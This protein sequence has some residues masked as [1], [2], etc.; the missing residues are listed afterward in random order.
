MYFCGERLGVRCTFSYSCIGE[1]FYT[2]FKKIVKIRR[3]IFSFFC[4]EETLASHSRPAYILP[5]AHY[6]AFYDWRKKEDQNL[7]NRLSVPSYPGLEHKL[8]YA[9]ARIGRCRDPALFFAKMRTL[10][11]FPRGAHGFRSDVRNQ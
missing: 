5:F 3:K 4:R 8:G 11:N 1:I 10:R 9:A 7:Q 2:A 6:R